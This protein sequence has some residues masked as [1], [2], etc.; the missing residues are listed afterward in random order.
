[1]SADDVVIVA[2]AIKVVSNDCDFKRVLIKKTRILS[3][4]LLSFRKQTSCL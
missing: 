2:M 3:M 4:F 1:M